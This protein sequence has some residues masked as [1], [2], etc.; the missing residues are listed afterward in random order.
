MTR[1][2]GESIRVE[3]T[4]WGNRPHWQFDG[5][6]LGS[7]EYGEWLGFPVG[8]HNTRPGF[9]FDSEVDVVTLVPPDDYWTATFH[10]PGNW[11][12]VYVD[13]CTPATWDGD[14]LRTVDLDLDVIR[15]APESPADSPFA[16]QNQRAAW[17]EVFIDDED[18]FAEHQVVYGYPTDVIQAARAS[19][20]TVFAA[21]RGRQAPY[22]GTHLPWLTVLTSHAWTRDGGPP[23][24]ARLDGP[25]SDAS[26]A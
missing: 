7:D 24:A 4:K 17:G 20:E 23:D 15:M 18:E 19:C 14:V 12:E 16:P 25:P 1:S 2:P 21:V 13:M 8:T 6:W 3:V 10:A 26:P 22:D 11:C 5:I 9:S